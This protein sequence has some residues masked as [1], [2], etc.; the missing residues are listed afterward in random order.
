MPRLVFRDRLGLV[1][2]I[3]GEHQALHAGDSSAC[4]ISRRTLTAKPSTT[5]KHTSGTAMDQLMPARPERAP[6][7]GVNT[8]PPTIAMTS[9][10]DASLRA[11][12]SPLTPSAKMVGYMIDMKKLLAIRA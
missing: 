1:G 2:E 8:A 4:P 9:T 3:E 6:I 5:A 12:P 7:A 10:D 11:S